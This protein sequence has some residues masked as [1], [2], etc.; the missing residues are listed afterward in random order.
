MALFPIV[1]N[2]VQ[3]NTDAVQ[4]IDAFRNGVRLL[5]DD[6]ACRASDSGFAQFSNGL[7][8]TSL[9]QVVFVDATAGLP[10]GTQYV[11]GIPV[12]P[13]GAICISIDVAVTYS[14]GLPFAANGA[15][16]AVSGAPWTP[17]A[18]GSALALW[19]DADDASTITLNGST[20][21]QW[22]DKSGNARNVSQATAANQPT[23]TA[24]GLNGKPVLTFDGTDWL[25]N[26]NPGAL[27]RNVAGGTV[28]AVM[29]YTDAVSNRIPVTVMNGTGLGVRLSTALQTA[30]TTNILSRRLDADA[31]ASSVTS[32]PAYTN[33]TSIIQVGVAR[34]S[35]GALDQ[36]VNGSAAGTGTFPSSGN[37][38]DT[39]SATLI[40]GGTSTDDG[41]TIGN[42][43]L[44][45]VGEVVTTNTA[46]STADRERLEGYF[47]WKWGLEAN[48]P[49]DHP[50]KN[51][52][53]TV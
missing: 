17:A 42:Q 21:S 24:S 35:A 22:N 43:M 11:N 34:Y 44:G 26:A 12:S 49:S 37:S 52:P 18:L 45:F 38:S 40:I 48:L 15:L 6:S 53:P 8:M 10:S 30:G 3:L 20:V 7:P 27:I 32:P 33:G 29:N 47:A 9:G 36:F 14:N 13:L 51:T 25:F 28:A 1:D 2:R 39:D 4:A 23:L 50:F 41:V 5:A 16:A 46:L 31:T 19:L